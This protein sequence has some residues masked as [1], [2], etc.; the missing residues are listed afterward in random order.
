MFFLV[1][2]ERSAGKI[3][4]L[5]PFPESRRD[6]AEEARLELELALSRAAVEREVVLLEAEDEAAL[7]NTHRRYFETSETLARAIS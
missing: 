5:R 7:H 6:D 4:T 3:K 1:E 2:Y